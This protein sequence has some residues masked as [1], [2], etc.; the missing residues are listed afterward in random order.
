MLLS[1]THHGSHYSQKPSSMTKVLMYQLQGFWIPYIFILVFS[2]N[3]ILTSFFSQP[4]WHFSFMSL[5]T[6]DSSMQFQLNKIIIF[7]SRSKSA[8]SKC[9][10]FKGL[11][12]QSFKFSLLTYK[13]G[14]WDFRHFQENVKTPYFKLIFQWSTS[15]TAE[16]LNSVRMF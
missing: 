1:C 8:I 12:C 11:E 16:E 15:Y 13:R 2:I 14:K 6:W 9:I 5:N 4:H 10:D 3:N 7:G